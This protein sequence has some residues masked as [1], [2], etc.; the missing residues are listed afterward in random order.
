MTISTIQRLYSILRGEPTLDPEEL[1]EHSAYEARRPSRCPVAYNPAVP[2]ET[3]DVVIVDEC[4]RSI[5]GLWR[6][7][8]DYFDA[9]MIGLTATPNKQ[10]FGFFNQNLVME[11]AH[12]QAVADGVNVDF[13]VYRIRTEITEQGGDDRRR[14]RRRSSAT[15]RRAASA[16]RSST[17]TSPTGAGRARPRRRRPRPDPHRDPHLPRPAVHRDLP[18][19][20]ARCRRR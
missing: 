19:P 20:H 16:G 9:F 2:L 10:A 8:L 17:T 18:R 13:D 14:P 1:D 7:V 3:F 15:A 11:Y 12:E 5:Y 4:H 6:Q